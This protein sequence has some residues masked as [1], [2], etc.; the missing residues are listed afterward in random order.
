MADDAK[1]GIKH[2]TEW[3]RIALVSDHHLINAFAKFFGAILP[4]EV[5]IFK[6]ADLED[7][8]KWI[9]EK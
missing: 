4:C 6:D 3:G 9:S 8:K 2:L 5:K 7:A 1:V